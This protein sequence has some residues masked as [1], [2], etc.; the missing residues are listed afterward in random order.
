MSEERRPGEERRVSGGRRAGE[1]GF[2]REPDPAKIRRM[3]SRPVVE[4]IGMPMDLGGNRRGVDMGPSGIR[5]SGL[6]AKLSEIG[7]RVK[8]RGNI[9]VA[10][11]DEGLATHA[12]RRVDPERMSRGPRAHNVKEIIRAC[13]ELATVVAD[14]ARAGN[15]PL[16]LIG[17]GV[18]LLLVV[19]SMLAYIRKLRRKVV[20]VP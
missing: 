20:A 15:I 2:L 17:F 19:S 11:L 13:E 10:D 9:R 14:I 18:V 5:Y 16:V 1:E 3:E 4:I 12:G 8:D 7:F 6:V